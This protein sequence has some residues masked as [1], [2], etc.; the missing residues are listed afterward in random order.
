MQKP[1][2]DFLSG[3]KRLQK[4]MNDQFVIKKSQ[5]PKDKE[6]EK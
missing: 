4:D 6:K 1:T 3:H 2:D 5:Q